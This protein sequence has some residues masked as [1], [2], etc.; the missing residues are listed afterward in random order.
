MQQGLV[1]YPV[2]SSGILN[3]RG[4]EIFRKAKLTIL[5]Q[6]GRQLNSFQWLNTGDGAGEMR[7]NLDGYA[8]GLYFL[9]IVDSDFDYLDDLRERS[10]VRVMRF[11]IR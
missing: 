4:L 8:S 11:Q 9:H 10:S 6:S 1:L 2:P 3:V 7:L 5:D